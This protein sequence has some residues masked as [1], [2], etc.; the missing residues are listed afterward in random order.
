MI[1]VADEKASSALGAAA[2]KAEE[3]AAMEASLEGFTAR[4]HGDGDS[5]SSPAKRRAAAAA[6]AAEAEE[7]EVLPLDWRGR[8]SLAYCV[9]LLALTNFARLLKRV[10]RCHVGRSA[11]GVGAW[12]Q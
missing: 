12:Q 11:W 8:V 7:R 1:A 5:P 10:S 4:V 3:A 6:A 2:R 9:D